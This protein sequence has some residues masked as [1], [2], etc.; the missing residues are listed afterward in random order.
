M[1]YQNK[2]VNMIYQKEIVNSPDW[3]EGMVT[4]IKFRKVNRCS[5]WQVKLDLQI[6]FREL[7]KENE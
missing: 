5:H 6:Y 2:I 3:F 4:P 1:I 7:E